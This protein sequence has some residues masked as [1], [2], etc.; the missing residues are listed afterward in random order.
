MRELLAKSR[1]PLS[2]FQH[3]QDVR[4]AGDAVFEQIR[5]DLNDS[6]VSPFP[7]RLL[8]LL[9]TAC[10]LHDVMKANSAFQKMVHTLGPPQKQPIRHEA[11]AAVMLS[12]GPLADW[13]SQMLPEKWERWAV[14]WAIA[15]HHFQLRRDIK[16]GLVRDTETRHVAIH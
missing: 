3:L 10:L 8:S 14:L 6:G 5:S 11:L 1:P 12:A 4:A 15:G 2:L 13:L 7:D 9:A 16:G